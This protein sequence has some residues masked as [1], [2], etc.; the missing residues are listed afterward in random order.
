MTVFISCSKYGFLIGNT[1]TF[2]ICIA[3]K[4]YQHA[5]DVQILKQCSDL[6]VELRAEYFCLALVTNDTWAL[7]RMIMLTQTWVGPSKSVRLQH[8]HCPK[9]FITLVLNHR[10]SENR[11]LQW[12][13]IYPTRRLWVSIPGLRF[14]IWLVSSAPN[15]HGL[16]SLLMILINVSQVKP[17]SRS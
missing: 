17:N 10:P 2:H 1:V 11:Y 14:G 5:T 9:T 12:I 7:G 6:C 8:W 15:L 13:K 3:I 16:D 4:L